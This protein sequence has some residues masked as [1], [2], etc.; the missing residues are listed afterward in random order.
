MTGRSI[1]PVLVVALL[2][3]LTPTEAG[4]TPRQLMWKQKAP[5]GLELTA[6][7]AT[8]L[9]GSVA[10]G[11]AGWS[12][13]YVA[14][15][16]PGGRALWYRWWRAARVKDVS[17][18]LAP[19]RSVVTAGSL[20][21]FGTHCAGWF[22]R[23]YG[24]EGG[25]R[26]FRRQRCDASSVDLSAV[27]VTKHRIVLAANRNPNGAGGTYQHDAF[28]MEMSSSGRLIRR[29]DIE[30][31]RPEWYETVE[32]VALGPGGTVFVT[33]AA[34]LGPWTTDPQ[35]GLPVAP[36]ADPYVMA[37]TPTGA[38]RWE[39]MLHDHGST[40]LYSGSSVDLSAGVLAAVAG[41]H[42]WGKPPA[43]RV[44]RFSMQGQ[45]LWRRTILKQKGLALSWAELSVAPTGGI[46]VVVGHAGRPLLRTFRANGTVAWSTRFGPFGVPRDGAYDHHDVDA[47]SAGVFV[48]GGEE[49]P[50]DANLGWTSQGWLYRFRP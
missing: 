43:Y 42:T 29:F 10:V 31:S 15:Y 5:A 46:S 11:A 39:A 33:G 40:H 27:A 21:G 36:N 24:P 26:W 22:V 50:L 41:M 8:P 3:V 20:F 34:D 49:A 25:L 47:T 13:V 14:R 32:D 17:V 44:V 7:A 6:V 19:D 12:P 30:P 35:V 2:V 4:A 9:G 37:F 1:V 28:V 18:A 48:A 23:V 45:R 16:S 38:I